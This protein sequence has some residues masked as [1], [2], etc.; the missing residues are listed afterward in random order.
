MSGRHQRQEEKDEE[1]GGKG[2]K[3]LQK[4]EE[5]KEYE[6][7]S[8][9]SWCQC[10]RRYFW[11]PYC[12][13]SCRED[14][15]SGPSYFAVERGEGLFRLLHVGM[16]EQIFLIDPE[17]EK[18][19]KVLAQGLTSSNFVQGV[20]I[21]GELMEVPDFFCRIFLATDLIKDK[22]HPVSLDYPARMKRMEQ[23]LQSIKVTKTPDFVVVQKRPLPFS[24][25]EKES[26]ISFPYPID[27]FLLIPS[28]LST[29][30]PGQ[31]LQ[32]W[33]YV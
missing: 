28:K 4:E 26:P 14:I 8:I 25:L 27:G 24:A 11:M 10:N 5:E 23:V 1:E 17:G 30:R 16:H 6:V 20:L 7:D 2:Q 15:A 9:V 33:V 22:Q 12:I 19:E 32:W 29:P 21:T 3:K 31:V 13:T 18:Q